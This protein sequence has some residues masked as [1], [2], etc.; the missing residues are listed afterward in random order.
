MDVKSAWLGV[1]LRYLREGG[2]EGLKA[3]WHMTWGLDIEEPYVNI[4]GQSFPESRKMELMNL[5]AGQE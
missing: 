5:F 3:V 1:L 4:R 2:R